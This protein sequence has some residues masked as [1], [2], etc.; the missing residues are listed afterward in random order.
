MT[1]AQIMRTFPAARRA[2]VERKSW[3]YAPETIDEMTQMPEFCEDCKVWH[4]AW[5][6]HGYE[7]LPETDVFLVHAWAC[8]Q[9]G[10]WEVVSTLDAGSKTEEEWTRMYDDLSER[11]FKQVE[12][13]E[14]VMA[15]IREA[16]A[17]KK[18]E[19]KE[20]GDKNEARIA[21]LYAL[22][23]EAMGERQMQVV[24][25]AGRALGH[26]TVYGD[27]TENTVLFWEAYFGEVIEAHKKV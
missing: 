21:P 11:S 26:T 17:K 1:P 25:D 4:N 23:L 19:R 20:L 13:Y 9:D 10:N 16:E 3:T 12:E 7:Y 18:A 24:L 27:M 8:D 5:F 6:G 14:K 15:P 2:A 22:A